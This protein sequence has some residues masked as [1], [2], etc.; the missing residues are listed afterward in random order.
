MSNRIGNFLK[1]VTT[2]GTAVALSATSLKVNTATVQAKGDNSGYLQVGSS[3]VLYSSG[4]GVRLGIPAA[5]S[6]PASIVFSSTRDGANEVELADIFIDVSVNGEG[7]T[8]T[9]TKA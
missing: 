1:T 5:N 8:V 7:A 4:E 9:W 3:T 6:T 2:G